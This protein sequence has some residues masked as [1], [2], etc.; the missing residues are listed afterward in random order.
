MNYINFY[1]NQIHSS[2]KKLLLLLSCI[3]FLFICCNKST[4][5]FED[6]DFGKVS[7]KN[8]LEKM[9]SNGIFKIYKDDKQDIEDTTSIGYNLKNNN[10]D[11]PMRVFL[12]EEFY[13]GKK[14]NFGSLRRMEFRIGENTNE[15]GIISRCS[16]KISKKFVDN[17]YKTYVTLYGEPDIIEIE[18]EYKKSNASSE[19]FFAEYREDSNKP[20]IID[21]TYFSGKKATWNKD[22]FN[23][24]FNIPTLK[25]TQ[26]YYQ[27][28]YSNPVVITYE[29]KSYKEELI[30]IKDSVSSK[31]D[32]NDI[33]EFKIVD[34]KFV[35]S[36]QFLIQ[37]SSIKLK[38]LYKVDFL[39]D[40]IVG[41]KYEFTVK[42]I[43]D[44]LI[45]KK[46][47]L[48]YELERKLGDDGNGV[49]GL[50]ETY[51]YYKDLLFDVGNEIKQMN[52]N[53]KLI[54]V[55]KELKLEDGRVLK[56]H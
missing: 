27:I 9:V 49:V 25:K 29:M 46:S 7:K 8:F 3:C 2:M 36:N 48:E 14:F 6:I 5:P 56:K 34:S 24:I 52:N 26:S 22:N 31:F 35:N 50:D 51:P 41:F 28:N 33:I 1:V 38:D 15:Y 21:E 37:L 43:N 10:M 55:I 30:R 39:T 42:D 32:P 12:N 19:D 40:K 53:F 20:K 16:G 47:N 4:P 54:I 23:L 45:F 18:N 13:K 44:K 17:L 11:F